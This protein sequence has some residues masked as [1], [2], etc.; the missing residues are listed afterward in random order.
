MKLK[1][2]HGSLF[3]FFVLGSE[4][5]E[6]ISTEYKL[7]IVDGIIGEVL[8]NKAVSNRFSL[9]FKPE[10][11]DYTEE[12]FLKLSRQEQNFIVEDW[13]IGVEVEASFENNP[14]TKK[15]YELLSELKIKSW[16][17]EFLSHNTDLLNGARVI[18]KTEDF[19]EIK[20]TVWLPNFKT[21]NFSGLE[22]MVISPTP[23]IVATFCIL[24]LSSGLLS[25][26][27]FISENISL[28]C[29]SKVFN[30]FL[31]L[32]IVV[33]SFEKAYSLACI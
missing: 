12:E 10:E 11:V 9:G 26:S 13:A 2:A 3:P 14:I 1:V 6:D 25:I 31:F 30:N 17:E 22:M 8:K 33:L 29:F 4:H 23:F 21:F 24:S 7:T 16:S 32:F 5:F 27:F 15:A 18:L 20:S 19:D 28:S